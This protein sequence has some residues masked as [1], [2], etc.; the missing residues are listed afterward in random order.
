MISKISIGSGIGG[1]LDYLMNEKK[2]PVVLVAQGMSDTKKKAKADFRAWASINPK[3]TK[4]VLHIPLSFSPADKQKLISDPHLKEKII[5]RYVELMSKQGYGL[6]KSQ[7]IAIEHHDTKHPHI[8]LVFNRIDENGKTIKDGFIAL[9]SK[10]VCKQ[11]TKEF[12]L[13]LAESKSKTINKDLQYGKEKLKTEIYQT[14][15]DLKLRNKYVSLNDIEKKLSEKNIELQLI[16]DDNGI[17]YGSYYTQKIGEKTIK[18][19]TSSIDKDLTLKKLVESHRLHL[20]R[21]SL[22]EEYK[23]RREITNVINDLDH[24]FVKYARDESR[25]QDDLATIITLGLFK[26]TKPRVL[27][28]SNFATAFELNNK[29]KAVKSVLASSLLQAF[30]KAKS[31]ED[32]QTRLNKQN[33]KTLALRREK[34][35]LVSS[36]DMHFL[37]TDLHPDLSYDYVHIHFQNNKQDAL[38]YLTLQFDHLKDQVKSIDE[39]SRMLPK[40]ITIDIKKIPTENGGFKE[41]ITFLVLCEQIK[42]NQLSKVANNWL[43][44]LAFGVN[45]PTLELNT[46]ADLKAIILEAI[47]HAVSQE[48]LKEIL[49]SKGIES[50]FKY[51]NQDN[52]VGV[53]FNHEGQSFK[54][55]DIGLSAKSITKKLPAKNDDQK[56]N[57]GLKL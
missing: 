27:N 56:P 44:G 13:T 23:Q 6:N 57:P 46:G 43:N 3:L 55:S 48:G 19:K 33:I 40:E 52:L 42:R 30:D 21:E 47:N 20:I 39:L 41:Q 31:F 8:H 9:N 7:Y 18:I 25:M 5:S 22:Q 16:I 29:R 11:I 12:D 54:G 28:R 1:C 36:G 34:K 50:I 37:S 4:N 2:G 32:L 51:D 49:K 38:S 14:L 10:K 24:S 15:F 26:Q 17:V 53:R 35:I 45:E